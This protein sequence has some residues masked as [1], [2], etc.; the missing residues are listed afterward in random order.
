MQLTKEGS[1]P[2]HE[3]FATWQGEGVHMGRSVFFIRTYG[4][5]VHCPW[6]DSAGTWHPK[7]VP[8]EV[9]RMWPEELAEEAVVAGMN[10]AVITGGEPTI[11]NLNSLVNALSDRGIRSH[12]ETSGAFPITGA[13]DWITLSPK[14]WKMPLQASVAQANEF[15]I[16][17]ETP[18]DIAFYYN[19]LLDLR[20]NDVAP[21][22]PI[23]LHPE[24]SQHENKQV[25][26]A[27]SEAVKKSDVLRAGW[28]LHKNYRVDQL[29]ARSAL[30][31]PLGG[32]ESK[33][34]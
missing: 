14:K 18:E 24:W 2:I 27:I 15:K 20:V 1:Y 6:C 30:L 16:I 21:L 22:R 25:L 33:G 11:F 5:P 7:W 8:K 29:D 17:V 32:D 13:L 34:Y 19:A 10:R 26:N 31:V 4:C 9:T 3:R 23:W 12:L 28:Q